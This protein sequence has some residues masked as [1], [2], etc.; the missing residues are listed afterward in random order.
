MYNY[1]IVFQYVYMQQS[2][3]ITTTV[4]L[5]YQLDHEFRSLDLPKLSKFLDT[6]AKHTCVILNII[7][8]G[9]S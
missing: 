9:K 8:L 1:L 7:Y 2:N 6:Y 3:Q 4:N 5:E